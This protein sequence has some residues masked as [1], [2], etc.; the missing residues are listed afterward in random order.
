M[1][2]DLLKYDFQYS[3]KEIEEKQYEKMLEYYKYRITSLISYIDDILWKENWVSNELI[4]IKV[5]I[6]DLSINSYN[7]ENLDYLLEVNNLWYE[8]FW[9]FDPEEIVNIDNKKL[10]SYIYTGEIILAYIEDYSKI[11]VL[12]KTSLIQ[13][14]FYTL[15][16]H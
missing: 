9:V 1:K 2:K 3:E 16:I 8:V 11:V 4:E 6:W 12:N 10:L 15:L 14:D 13:Q 7:Y 5:I